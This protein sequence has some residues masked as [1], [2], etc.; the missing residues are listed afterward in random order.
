[1]ENSFVC[2]WKED[3]S[4][5]HIE[6]DST[7]SHTLKDAAVW[8]CYAVL[9]I[10]LMDGAFSISI[11]Y[12]FDR[13][14]KRNQKDSLAVCLYPTETCPWFFHLMEAQWYWQWWAFLFNSVTYKIMTSSK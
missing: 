5:M 13:I 11:S 12:E 2:L 7:H 14:R 1:M 4:K 8:I 10:A 9:D 3:A 6:Y